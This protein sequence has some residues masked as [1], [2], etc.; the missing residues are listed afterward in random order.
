M[1]YIQIIIPAFLGLITLTSCEGLLTTTV[2]LDPPEYT[3]QLVTHVRVEDSTQYLR[4]I[5]TRTFGALETVTNQNNYYIKGATVEMFENGQK[6]ATL[7]PLSNDSA[8]VY[9]TKLP[10]TPQVG[11]T[12][13]LRA[14]HPNFETITATQIMPGKPT[15]QDFTLDRNALSPDGS[16]IYKM[17][18]TLKD[19]PGT[20]NYYEVSAGLLYYYESFIFDDLG[21]IIGRDTVGSQFFSVFFDQL[22]DQ[23]L[24]PGVGNTVLITDQLIDGQ[25]YPFKADFYP[26][27]VI[28]GVDTSAY[29]ITIRSITPEYYQWSRSYRQRYDNEFNIFAEPVTVYTNFD[30]GLGVFGLTN[31][32]K[33][34]VK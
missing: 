24:V 32:R 9:V 12:Y 18:F 27:V 5:M 17:G 7:T 10:N 3:P 13:E 34:I 6:L 30:K 11:K 15:A 2:E 29:D 4:V 20:P 28:G 1:R 19:Q 33:Y 8:W 22:L 16:R 25:D 23:N 31:G 26:T 14:S 21:N